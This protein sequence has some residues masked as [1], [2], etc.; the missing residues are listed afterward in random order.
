NPKTWLVSMAAEICPCRM[1]WNAGRTLR[2][3]DAEDQSVLILPVLNMIFCKE[4]RYIVWLAACCAI[5]TSLV[6]AVNIFIDPFFVFGWKGHPKLNEI[7]IE[8]V[9]SPELS[10]FYSL[11]RIGPSTLIFGS[12]RAQIGLDPDHS[13]FNDKPVFNMA[14]AG[15]TMR[16]I[17]RI[18]QHVMTK[19]RVKTVVLALDF[20]MFNA[21]NSVAWEDYRLEGG[22]NA[23]VLAPLWRGTGYVEDY[24]E[25]TLPET[26]IAASW[27]TWIWNA[28]GGGMSWVQLPNG[29]NVLLNPQSYDQHQSFMSVES[30]YLRNI[31]G[32]AFCVDGPC[33]QGRRSQIS[34]F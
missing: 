25:A 8:A 33:L 21:S 7:R 17:Q 34:E 12:S 19:R 4:V 15:A 27:A 26:T 22:A 1:A 3:D 31:W 10:K 29:F 18:F 5:V 16:R 32:P 30:N 13:A 28:R 23:S 2:S 6:A 9:N 20:F 11:K 24:L 14:Y